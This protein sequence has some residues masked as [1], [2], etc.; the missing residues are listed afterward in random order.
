MSAAVPPGVLGVAAGHTLQAAS[1]VRD[2]ELQG[3]VGVPGDRRVLRAPHRDRDRR[4]G[5]SRGGELSLD[6]GLYPLPDNEWTR[7]K[8]G[9]KALVYMASGAVPVVSPV[10]V[11]RDI[12]EDG[13]R[14][15]HAA[16]D[17]GWVHAVDR[18]LADPELRTEMSVRGRAYVEEHFSV[19]ALHPGFTA[20]L[21]DAAERRR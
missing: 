17:D 1:I 21:R 5:K 13:V 6:V 19:R 14:G 2:G 16:D 12:V 3:R 15:F 20:A 7:G 10:G 11:S 4:I 8:C 18:L 9:Y